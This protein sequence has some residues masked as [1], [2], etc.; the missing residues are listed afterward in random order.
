MKK[1]LMLSLGLFVLIAAVA[2]I[3]C[4]QQDDGQHLM[5]S[6]A[7]VGVGS[8][9]GVQGQYCTDLFAGQTIAAGN[10]CIEILDHGDTEELCITYITT[11][12]WVLIET[13][14]WVGE[15]LA[16][17]PQTRKGN[18]Q[19][20]NFPYHSGDIT[21]QT[22][23]TFCVDLNQY[24]TEGG[25]VD[26]CG[27]MLY[28]AT[29]AVVA[30]DIDG[31][32]IYD[33]QETAWG[34]GDRMVARGNWSTYFTIKLECDLGGVGNESGETA[35]A[36][37][38]AGDANCFIDI[39][40]EGINRWGWTNG[41][42][43]PGTYYLDIYA[44]A[45]QCDITN[46]TLVGLLTV[47]YDGAIATVTYETCGDYK[48]DE[49]HLYVGNNI[50]AWDDNPADPGYT[51]APG[52]FPYTDDDIDTNSYT[53]TIDGLSG[54]IYV[55]AHAVVVGDY[56]LGDCGVRG[57][58]PPCIPGFDYDAFETEINDLGGDDG[59]VTVNVVHQSGIANQPYF[60]G[61]L[62]A[63][64]GLPFYCIDLDNTIYSNRDY[65]AILYSTYDGSIPFVNQPE[66]LDLLNYVLN[67]FKIGDLASDGTA[68]TGGD[69]QRVL[70]SLV[71]G[72]LPAP[73][74]YSSGSSTDLR[75]NEILAA[76]NASGE[77]FE[78]PC[79]GV[80]GVVVVPVTCD[81]SS[82]A[83]QGLIAQMLVTEF[84]AVCTVCP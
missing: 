23:Y 82:Q 41:A 21:G 15:D 13:Q 61:S 76:A 2:F 42:Y 55:V 7:T 83:A 56:S 84:E 39:P 45:G 12:D 73:G 43:G 36:Y 1:V 68:F 22:S 16:D 64:T 5:G 4:S 54:S 60:L 81:G 6:M 51:V 44:G 31:D 48:M 32:G 19:I 17:M 74:A 38:C 59:L 63:T 35:F 37:D 26:L 9:N 34:D 25:A 3:G 77:G 69:I 27:L 65:C 29:H 72:S 75:V 79:D 49:V 67:T 62:G 11:G 10:V 28:A 47:V 66:N 24:G 8:I 78:P 18:P 71:Y 57:C 30:R 14:A 53:F 52:K 40:D 20:G 46:G 33:E 80:V 70:W 50:L 58:V